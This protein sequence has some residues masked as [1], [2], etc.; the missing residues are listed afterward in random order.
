MYR[1]KQANN[2]G[3]EEVGAK[4]RW[5]ERRKFLSLLE[6]RWLPERESSWE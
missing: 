1:H 2:N 3:Q 4:A 6:R 5:D